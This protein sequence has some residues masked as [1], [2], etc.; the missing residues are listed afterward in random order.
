MTY[1]VKT[2]FITF[3][4]LVSPFHVIKPSVCFV[5]KK[6]NWTVIV[7]LHICRPSNFGVLIFRPFDFRRFDFRGFD[8]SAFRVFGVLNFGVL[9]FGVLI[10][11]PFDFGVL[12]FGLSTI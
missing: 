9:I 6:M 11:R 8:Y 5:M 4:I 2:V 12:S 10:F 7:G 3:F 1:L